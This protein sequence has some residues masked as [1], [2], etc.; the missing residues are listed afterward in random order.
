[1]RR[2]G[3]GAAMTIG[4]G[5]AIESSWVT[6]ANFM[7]VSSFSLSIELRAMT[8]FLNHPV[9]SSSGRAEQGAGS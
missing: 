4:F 6:D 7:V 9:L 2:R 1:M 3:D 8:D 5:S